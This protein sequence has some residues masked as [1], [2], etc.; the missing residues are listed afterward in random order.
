MIAHRTN[1]FR[2]YDRTTHAVSPADRHMTIAVIFLVICSASEVE[3]HQFVFFFPGPVLPLGQKRPHI[4]KPGL[5]S[6]RFAFHLL[7][8]RN[9]GGRR[10][11][12]RK[13]ICSGLMDMRRATRMHCLHFSQSKWLR[14]RVTSSVFRGRHAPLNERLF[15]CTPTNKVGR[16]YGQAMPGQAAPRETSDGGDLPAALSSLP[17]PSR[18]LRPDN[19]SAGPCPD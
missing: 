7:N 13:Q 15:R 6:L 3:K 2:R 4:V 9:V 18:T 14:I 8:S 10:K 16:L 11:S 12:C 1:A 17:P 19:E 5:L